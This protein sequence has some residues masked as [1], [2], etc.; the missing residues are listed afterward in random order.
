MRNLPFD[1][2]PAKLFLFRDAHTLSRTSHLSIGRCKDVG[3]TAA[4]GRGVRPDAA[5]RGVQLWSAKVLMLSC[6]G[7][8]EGSISQ[9]NRPAGGRTISQFFAQISSDIQTRKV[10]SDLR[11]F[12]WNRQRH[13]MDKPRTAHLDSTLK[14]GRQVDLK[15]CSK[16][17]S[18]LRCG[19]Q[20]APYSP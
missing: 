14:V 10:P 16:F 4:S 15:F 12:S 3:I 2:A 11:N 1:T 20:P 6:R 9:G 19:A 18:R 13:S 17:H 8:G 7:G 5:D